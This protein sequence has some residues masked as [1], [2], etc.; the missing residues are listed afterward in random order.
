MSGASVSWRE[1]TSTDLMWPGKSQPDS[2]VVAVLPPRQET[3]WFYFP[4]WEGY[5][6]SKAVMGIG[7]C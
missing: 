1:A 7:D 2:S 4:Y 5:R 6:L 3:G